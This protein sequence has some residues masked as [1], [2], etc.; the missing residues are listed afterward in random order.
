LPHTPRAS[1][2]LS[3][4]WLSAATVAL[5][6]SCSLHAQAP[7]NSSGPH[8]SVATIKK[9]IRLVEVEVIA[10]D[11]K[12]HPVTDLAAADFTLKD[13]GR[14]QKIRFFASQ[15]NK[16]EHEP[17]TAPHS[18]PGPN[19]PPPNSQT[20]SN[21]RSSTA[22]PVVILIDLLNTSSDNQPGVKTALVAALGRIHSNSPIALL[23]LGDGL[24]LV[25][26]FTTDAGA[27]ALQLQKP[28]VAKQEGFGPAVT[29]PKTANAKANEAILKAALTTFRFQTAAQF[30]R[31]M[32]ALNLIGNQLGLMRGRK[33]LIWIGSGLSVGPSDWPQVR[34]VIDKLNDADVGVYT[35]D[36]RGVLLDYGIGADVDPQDQLG[37]WLADQAETRGDILQ[38]MATNTGGVPYRNTNALDDAVT[39]AV[40]DTTT[41]YTLSYY[42]QHGDWQGKS[43]K[44]EVRVSRPGINLRYRS[45]YTAVPEANPEVADQQRTLQLIAASPLDFPGVRFSVEVKPSKTA[46]QDAT[47]VNFIVHVPASELRLSSQEDRS[48]G[49]LQF[50]FFQRKI[51]GEDV[52]SST[53]T[54]SFQLK[55]SEFESAIA[56]GITFTLPLKL[57]PTAAKVRV[58]LKDDNSG[59]VG[60][61]DVPVNPAAISGAPQ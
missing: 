12:G 26:D 31:T 52:A 14:L 13:N 32:A 47:A 41:V 5:L 59:R 40:E 55:P 24:K 50:L 30:D 45:G 57:R 4:I 46:L 33:S 8:Q 37:P 44:I 7:S 2:L 21:D 6:V 22:A 56:Q 28:S 61:V 48:V 20:F 39:R 10:K 29:A 54:Y 58:L 35:I 25:S 3:P 42:P 34:N 36:A 38:V 23:T 1:R 51:S 18:V 53:S 15:Q 11:K 49:V 9:T 17:D 60:S 16:T 43:H 19:A 27:I